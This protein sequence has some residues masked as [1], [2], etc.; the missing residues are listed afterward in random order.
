LNESVDQER[1]RQDADHGKNY[2]Y[3]HV[4]LTGECLYQRVRKRTLLRRML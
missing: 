1:A 4:M 2:L 3:H